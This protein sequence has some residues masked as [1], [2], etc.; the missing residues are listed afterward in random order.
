MSEETGLVPQATFVCLDDAGAVVGFGTCDLAD[1]DGITSRPDLY[2]NPVLFEDRRVIPV[3]HIYDS[4]T[5][6]ASAPPAPPVDLPAHL[7]LVR[8]QAETSPLP[9]VIAGERVPLAIGT[10]R[11][12]ASLQGTYTAIKDGLRPDGATFKFAD[13]VPRQV[14]NEDMLAAIVAAL[15]HIQ[16]CFD[17]ERLVR[18]RIDDGSLATETMTGEA[19]AETL[20]SLTTPPE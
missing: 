1:W 18:L 4:D 14:S 16:A 6:E 19:F 10:D 13:G 11:D 2:P 9:V 15:G 5:G 7:A 3:G 17:A 20:E 12:R 8:W